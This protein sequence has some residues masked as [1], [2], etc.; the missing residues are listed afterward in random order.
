MRVAAVRAPAA[1]VVREREGGAV[2][3]EG[4]PSLGKGAPGGGV[5][6][7][8]SGGGSASCGKRKARAGRPG[9]GWASAQSGKRVFFKFRGKYCVGK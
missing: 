1:A 4:G 2:F 3:K 9:F 8:D 7:A 5:A 6:G